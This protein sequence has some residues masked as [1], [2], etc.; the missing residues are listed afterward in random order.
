L[1][2]ITARKKR[3]ARDDATPE[4]IKSG[5]KNWENAIEGNRPYRAILRRWAFRPYYRDDGKLIYAGRAG[6]GMTE[7]ELTG[8]LK[9]LR[10]LASGKMSVDVPPPR[11]TR[12]GKPLVLSR[13]HWVRPELVAEVT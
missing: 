11:T 10:P 1:H 8:L 13:L 2:A 9:K 5:R 12:F 6:T 7:S 4:K 3:P